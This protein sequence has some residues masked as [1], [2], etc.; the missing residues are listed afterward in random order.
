MTAS[1]STASSGSASVSHAPADCRASSTFDGISDPD[2]ILAVLGRHA[3]TRP[4]AV[5][6]GIWDRYL[7]EGPMMK[8]LPLPVD[9][10]GDPVGAIDLMADELVARYGEGLAAI[11]P[12]DFPGPVRLWPLLLDDGQIVCLEHHFAIGTT[13]VHA[14]PKDLDRAIRGL[15]LPDSRVS[16]RK[17]CGEPVAT[18]TATQR[19]LNLGDYAV[20]LIGPRRPQ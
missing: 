17:P 12:S 10:D 7:N 1:E 14:N 3:C 13:I 16:W 5:T 2:Q 8:H 11:D 20:Q 6:R 18:E 19:V 15:G 9:V 4:Q